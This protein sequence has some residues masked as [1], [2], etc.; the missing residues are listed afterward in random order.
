MQDDEFAPVPP[1][2][3][4][5]GTRKTGAKRA[6]SFGALAQE[7]RREYLAQT[8]AETGHIRKE[9]G[10]CPSSDEEEKIRGGQVKKLRKQS[11]PCNVAATPPP[12]SPAPTTPGSSPVIRTRNLKLKIGLAPLEANLEN[13][14]IFKSKAET[15]SENKER[16]LRKENLQ[17]LGKNSQAKPYAKPPPMNLQRNPSMFGPELPQ[18]QNTLLPPAPTGNSRPS[19]GHSTPPTLG[20]SKTLTSALKSAFSPSS[21]SA[22]PA[23]KPVSQSADIGATPASQKTKLLRKVRRLAP[24]RRISFTSLAPPGDEADADGEGDGDEK[25]GRIELGSAFQLH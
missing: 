8:P 21:T 23:S 5:P 17:S 18:V 16:V 6:P 14:K 24:A 12:D 1:P 25:G 3:D 11:I 10:H 15:K 9:S 2:K 7:T 4:L 19:H 22:S 13:P 20:V